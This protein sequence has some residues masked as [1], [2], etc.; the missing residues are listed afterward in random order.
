MVG[1]RS[2]L[3]Y[4]CLEVLDSIRQCSILNVDQG[5]FFV[6]MAP[7]GRGRKKV[8]QK[9]PNGTIL[10][11]VAK[12]QWK[13]IEPIGEGGFGVIYSVE[14]V[15]STSKDN[16]SY[17]AKVEPHSNGPLFV[18][19][20]FFMR[21]LQPKMISDYKRDKNISFLGLP[22]YIGGGT[23]KQDD[24]EHRFLIMER[25]GDS[26]DE[27]IKRTN[28]V[29]YKLLGTF[30]AQIIDALRYI[31][32]RGYAHMDIKPENLLLKFKSKDDA[33]YLIDFG[34]VD[35]CTTDN[36]FSPDKKK[37]HNGTTLYTSRDSHQGVVTKRGDLEILGYNILQWL[38]VELPWTKD[39]KNLVVVHNKKVELLNDIQKVL[40]NDV[41]ESIIE[42]FNYVNNLEH[43]E[44]P[45]YN[46]IKSLFEKLDRVQKTNSKKRKPTV[47]A[48]SP[49]KRVNLNDEVSE[50]EN[51]SVA[52][53]GRKPLIRKPV[54][55]P[56]LTD[57][58]YN[59]PSVATK[60]KPAA[61]KRITSPPKKVTPK[62]ITS[63]KK[64][65]TK[66]ITS[67]KKSV[68]ANK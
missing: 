50:E 44:T 6:D 55:R 15:I 35:R 37:Q 36:V 11:D 58:K 67:P 52:S 30:C 32:E 25:F 53:R 38:R 56:V 10:T 14:K 46:Y 57:D 51:I 29:N 59:I 54:E 3:A 49:P 13:I 28:L 61:R 31:H 12:L 45:D 40:G 17:V 16:T 63:P 18:E 24:V 27:K 68:K 66:R 47:D 39:I 64:I 23:H 19:K 42:Y 7:K 1:L 48:S 5:I 41:P 4:E 60:S 8:L 65:T 9:L 26:I 21:H 62:R 34:I 33:V 20:N 43:N 2:K 22:E